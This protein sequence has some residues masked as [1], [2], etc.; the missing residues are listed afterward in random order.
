MEQ[1][2]ATQLGRIQHFADGAANRFVEVMHSGMD[3]GRA[4]VGDQEL[5]EGDAVWLLP[6]GD[7]INA[8]DDLIDPRPVA[9]HTLLFEVGSPIGRYT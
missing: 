6:G 4:L 1:N 7:P 8:I 2:D 9:C 3:E 5:I